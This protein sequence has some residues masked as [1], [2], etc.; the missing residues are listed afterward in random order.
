MIGK[1]RVWHNPQVGWCEK[2]FYIP[3]NSVEEAKFVMDI[4]AAYDMYQ[5]QNEVKSDYANESGLEA[6]D[7]E[8]KEWNEWY[9]ETDTE[10]YDD[11]EDYIESDL[12]LSGERLK[13]KENEKVL[14]SQIDKKVFSEMR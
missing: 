7:E 10:C 14:F 3:V 9:F 13:A 1:F 6:Y 11:V 5:L 12:C 4:L 2:P 8:S